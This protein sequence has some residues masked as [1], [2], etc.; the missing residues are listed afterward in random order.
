MADLILL[1]DDDSALAA[2]VE[3]MLAKAGYGV[4]LA[5]S[6]G[7]AR[8]IIADSEPGLIILDRIL[9]TKMGLDSAG[10][11]GLSLKFHRESCRRTDQRTVGRASRPGRMTTCEAL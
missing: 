2:A 8:A 1:I 7:A 5:E 9:R 10:R 3:H 11:S 6:A 4:L